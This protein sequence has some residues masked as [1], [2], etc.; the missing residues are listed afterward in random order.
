MRNIL[1]QNHQNVCVH[2]CEDLYIKT[3]CVWC[4]E[5]EAIRHQRRSQGKLSRINTYSAWNNFKRYAF[6]IEDR[7][8]R[9]RL[10]LLDESTSVLSDPFANDIMY[11]HACWLKYITHTNQNFRRSENTK[12]LQNIYLSEARTLFFRHVDSVI[13]NEHE[14]RS[15]QSLLAD[16]KRIISDFGYP[17]GDVKSFFLKDLLINEYKYAIGFN[18]RN[19]MNTSA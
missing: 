9:G 16:Y 12:N 13:F 18:D 5:E 1:D 17:V 10:T 15:L 11:H 4:K 2:H 6:L 14:I 19:E 7:E 8:L 3:K